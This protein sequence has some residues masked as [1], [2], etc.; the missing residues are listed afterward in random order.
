KMISMK[1]ML[2]CIALLASLGPVVAQA[3]QDPYPLLTINFPI[4]VTSTF[5]MYSCSNLPITL[6][7]SSNG[8]V[9]V[10]SSDL[11]YQAVVEDGWESLTEDFPKNQDG[12]LLIE[13][14]TGDSLNPASEPV[15]LDADPSDPDVDPLEIDISLTDLIGLTEPNGV[16]ELQEAITEAFKDYVL[17]SVKRVVATGGSEV[18]GDP[19]E[20][21]PDQLDLPP[22]K[23]CPCTCPL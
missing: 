13:K 4:T 9:S 22:C 2:S 8:G 6:I 12:D 15:N 3:Q 21:E 1:V 7:L 17:S 16:S 10:T 23:G 14:A 18:G 19:I 20:G 5:G 11:E